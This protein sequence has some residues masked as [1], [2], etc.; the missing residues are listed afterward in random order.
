MCAALPACLYASLYLSLSLCLSFCICL[1]L[2]VSLSLCVSVCMSLCLAV[3]LSACLP[4]CLSTCLSVCLSASPCVSLRPCR[5]YGRLCSLTWCVRCGISAMG[6]GFDVV[7]QRSERGVRAARIRVFPT[8]TV[9]SLQKKIFA[10]TNIP[11]VQ[12]NLA[13]GGMRLSTGNLRDYGLQPGDTIEQAPLPVQRPSGVPLTPQVPSARPSAKPRTPS[14]TTPSDGMSRV[15][16]ARE[17][18]SPRGARSDTLR[19]DPSWQMRAASARSAG[20]AGP[21]PTQ[22]PATP[23]GTLSG[24]SA[25]PPTATELALASRRG[26]QSKPMPWSAQYKASSSQG[27]G[28]VNPN[29]TLTPRHYGDFPP[30]STAATNPCIGRWSFLLTFVPR[31]CE[32]RH[33]ENRTCQCLAVVVAWLKWSRSATARQQQL[34]KRTRKITW[35]QL[36]RPAPV[37]RIRAP[38]GACRRQV[39]ILDLATLPRRPS[40]RNRYQRSRNTMR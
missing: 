5:L 10:A 29:S 8:E 39:V 30:V 25:R 6:S 11:P 12:Q 20:G 15:A 28:V 21:S 17:M 31:G 38:G 33:G 37:R 23:G 27:F 22:F 4:V 35:R 13:L 1:C 32:C 18:N 9:A 40:L 34:A 3:S 19:Y 24:R 16:L 2:S 26:T 36:C 14:P 7:F